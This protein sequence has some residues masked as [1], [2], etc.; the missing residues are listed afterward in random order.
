MRLQPVLVPRN[1]GEVGIIVGTWVLF[2]CG[3]A[4]FA[5]LTA[6][7]AKAG[8]KNVDS[9]LATAIRTVVILLFSWLLVFLTG[10]LEALPLVSKRSLVFLVLS[11]LATGFSWLFY[12]KALQL[13]DVNKVAPIDKSS[14][15]LTMTLSF[16]L[17]GEPISIAKMAGMTG[18]GAGTLLMIQRRDAEAPSHDNGGWLFFA[19]LSVLFA[20][21]TTILAKIG[22]E[23]VDS[24]LATAI[25]TAVVLLLAW[26]IVFQR[27][28]QRG[29]LS[30]GSSSWFFLIFSGFATGFSWLCFYKALKDGPASVVVPI[31]KLS[32]L[33]TVLFAY[34]FFKEK[35]SARASVGLILLVAGTL[36]LLV[37]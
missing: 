1:P 28:K 31:D 10:G 17:L 30:I 15:I 27:G 19:L 32:I 34:A 23:N 3:S 18:I 5:G 7:L 2:A 11:G 36:L 4:F 25:R 29:I 26:L 9:D 12:F 16:F 20:S 24:N 8:V 33:F 21:L 22:V 6:V 37:K 35:L 14:T 13:G